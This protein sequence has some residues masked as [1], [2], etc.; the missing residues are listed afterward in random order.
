M[1]AG[2]VLLSAAFLLVGAV[3]LMRRSQLVAW[4]MCID[5]RRSTLD[6]DA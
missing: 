5:G 1:P 2:F 6:E 4:L 3:V